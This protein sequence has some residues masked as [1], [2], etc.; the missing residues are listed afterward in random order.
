MR[1]SMEMKMRRTGMSMSEVKIRLEKWTI[2][3]TRRSWKQKP[4]LRHPK[5]VIKLLFLKKKLNG[6]KLKAITEVTPIPI[7]IPIQ[8]IFLQ[9]EDIED[10]PQSEDSVY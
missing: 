2:I 9:H 1:E 7:P 6:P 4:D 5:E 10:G 3:E 8:E